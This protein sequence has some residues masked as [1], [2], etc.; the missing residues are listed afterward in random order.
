MGLLT[1]GTILVGIVYNM[2]SEV[3]CLVSPDVSV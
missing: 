1:L 2:I 3:N